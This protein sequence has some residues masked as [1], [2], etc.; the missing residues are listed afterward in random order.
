MKT[1]VNQLKGKKLNLMNKFLGGVA[2]A[3]LLMGCSAL[4]NGNV[5]VYDIDTKTGIYDYTDGLNIPEH[6]DPMLVL[7]DWMISLDWATQYE[8]EI[9]IVEDWMLSLDQ[10]NYTGIHFSRIEENCLE[11]WMLD[12][13]FASNMIQTDYIEDTVQNVSP[14]MLSTDGFST[15]NETPD[16]LMFESIVA[17][18]VMLF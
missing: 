4:H 18:D 9:I 11:N 8:D 7:E 5:S 6:H 13:N 16:S 10:W 15:E 3:I 17:M 1:K 12:I 14:W 2:L